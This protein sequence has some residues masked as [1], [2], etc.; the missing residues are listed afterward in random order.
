MEQR[1]VQQLIAQATV[2]AFDEPV[3]LRL[4]GRDVMPGDAWR[5]VHTGT[6]VEVSWPS[7][8]RMTA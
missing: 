5:S 3:L 8:A 1:L 6:A 2:E 4:A 7:S